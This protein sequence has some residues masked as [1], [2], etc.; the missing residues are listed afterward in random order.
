VEAAHET[1]NLG[2]A[3]LAERV[4]AHLVYG[5]G[6]RTSSVQGSGDVVGDR[7]VPDQIRRALA[8]NDGRNLG[9][10][11]TGAFRQ[12]LVAIDLISGPQPCSGDQ[13]N[14]LKHG[15]RQ[16][17]KFIHRLVHGPSGSAERRKVQHGVE[18]P[19]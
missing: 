11:L 7:F 17:R 10:R 19:K 14:Q 13:R 9:N 5:L 15:F 4:Y 2:H 16:R 1:N 3:L 8:R 18:R 6:Q 12:A